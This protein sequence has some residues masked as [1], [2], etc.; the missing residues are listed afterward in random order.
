MSFLVVGTDTEVGKTV[1][2]AALVLKLA[3]ARRVAYWKPIATGAIEGRDVEEVGRLTAG[4]AA[5]VL[6]ESFLFDP[7]VSPHLAA[8][9][10]GRAIDRERVNADFAAHRAASPGRAL[11]IEGVGGLLVPLDDVG[12]LFPDL[13]A[14]WGLPCVVVARSGLGTINHTLLT[15]EAARRRGLAVAGVIFNG[16]PHMENQR[17]IERLGDVE[18]F[19]TLPRLQPLSAAALGAAAATLDPEGRLEALCDRAL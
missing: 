5:E 19:G 1:V 2:S 13:V 16:M 7:P 11:V 14:P 4:T 17:A 3:A 18:V 10:A 9:L 6:A 15:L 12:T 8:R